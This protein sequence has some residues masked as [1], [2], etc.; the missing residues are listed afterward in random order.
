MSS[1][2]AT[3][4]RC[5]SPVTTVWP[6]RGA[7]LWGLGKVCSE[8]TLGP[9]PSAAAPSPTASVAT[10]LGP[11]G[12]DCGLTWASFPG[13]PTLHVSILHLVHHSPELMEAQPVCLLVPGSLSQVD[14]KFFARRT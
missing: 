1:A 4:L 14:L 2:D 8:Q 11:T 7:P 6:S 3:R 13:S 5:G 12:D 10:L 9:G